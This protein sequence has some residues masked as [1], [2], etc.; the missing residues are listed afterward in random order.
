VAEGR[1][2]QDL[3]YR[4]NVIRVEL[5]PL[6]ERRDDVPVLAERFVQRF[7]G[8]MGKAIAGFTADALRAL[9]DYDFPGNVRELENVIER[10]VAL[11]G[12]SRIGRFL[13]ACS[14]AQRGP[15]APRLLA[16]PPRFPGLSSLGAVP[17]GGCGRT[18]G[19]ARGVER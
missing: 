9:T 17:S 11:A 4:L 15:N 2:R 19:G 3:Y 16:F 13:E 5:P 6:R 7:S 18:S 14:R 8:E 1:F 10:A 12:S